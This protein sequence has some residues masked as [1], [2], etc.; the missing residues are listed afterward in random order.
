[1]LRK[2]RAAES[3]HA[4]SS[5]SFHAQALVFRIKVESFRVRLKVVVF[6]NGDDHDRANQVVG[7]IPGLLYLS[8][9]ISIINKLAQFKARS[10]ESLY[11]YV[12]CELTAYCDYL[13]CALRGLLRGH[14][15]SL[16]I[17][18]EVPLL[19]STTNSLAVRKKCF[20]RHRKY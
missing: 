17:F 15:S 14:N 20:C 11:T 4:T 8:Y 5:I 16:F 3:T 12:L 2:L 13:A 18:S 10:S 19:S 9:N 1:M 6:T 7:P